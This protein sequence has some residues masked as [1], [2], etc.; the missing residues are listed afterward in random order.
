MWTLYKKTEFK[1]D[2]EDDY[3]K[4]SIR[5]I[6]VEVKDLVEFQ[7]NIVREKKKNNNNYDVSYKELMQIP[8]ENE[9]YYIIR[10]LKVPFEEKEEFIEY[11]Q[12]KKGEDYVEEKGYLETDIFTIRHSEQEHYAKFKEEK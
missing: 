10:V 12:T 4:C 6:L 1:R 9:L 3:F 7:D 2:N 11:L 8:N 5:Y